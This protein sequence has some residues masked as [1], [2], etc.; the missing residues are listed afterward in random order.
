MKKTRNKIPVDKKREAVAL[1]VS[2]AKTAQEIANEFNVDLHCIYR[3]R[4]LFDEE[5]KGIEVTHLV[6]NYSQKELA[7]VISRQQEEIAEYQKKVAEQTLIIDL[8]KKLR[9]QGILPSES[10]LSGLIATMKKL[11][12]K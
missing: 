1:Y 12:R 3:W 6:E 9:R 10:E 2:G 4:T 8:L 11:D 5:A 7:K